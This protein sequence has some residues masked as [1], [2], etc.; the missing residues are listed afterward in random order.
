MIKFVPRT[1]FGEKNLCSRKDNTLT[2]TEET[3][4]CGKRRVR[5]ENEFLCFAMFVDVADVYHS[6]LRRD[7]IRVAGKD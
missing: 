5:V 7:F 6:I 3:D 4:N 2:S 1:Y